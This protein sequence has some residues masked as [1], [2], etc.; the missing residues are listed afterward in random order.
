MVAASVFSEFFVLWS[1]TL[2]CSTTSRE[3]RGGRP[4]FA[5]TSMLPVAALGRRVAP[6]GSIDVG[7]KFGLPPLPSRD[8]V[9]HSSVADQRTKNSLKTLAATIRATAN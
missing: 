6:S 1:A 9:L 8:V 4:N 2:E 3:G 7:A 5:P